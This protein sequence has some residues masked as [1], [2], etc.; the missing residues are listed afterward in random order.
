[1]SDRKAEAL[2]S[3]KLEK[4]NHETASLVEMG[5]KHYIIFTSESVGESKAADMSLQI[6]QDHVAVK[7]KSFKPNSRIDGEVIY[8]LKV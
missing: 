3:L 5:D 1:M 8:D 7:K 2:E 6:N 4:A